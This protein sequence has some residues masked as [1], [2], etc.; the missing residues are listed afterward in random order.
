M[1]G[2]AVMGGVVGR[3]MVDRA[4]GGAENFISGGATCTYLN[5]L[6]GVRL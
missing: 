4:E 6:F 5:S 3:A 2:A 1:G